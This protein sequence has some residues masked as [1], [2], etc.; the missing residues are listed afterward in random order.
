MK[1]LTK[2]FLSEADREKILKAVEKAEA[3]TSGEIVPMVV[4]CSYHYPLANVIGAITIAFPLSILL[5]QIVGELFWIGSKNMWLFIG[6]LT[7]TFTVFLAIVKRVPW[8]KRIFISKKEMEEEVREAALTGFF[9]EEL[10][11]TRDETGVLIFISI[12]EHKV[13]VLADK[14]INAKVPEGHW[15]GIVSHIVDG[16]KNRRQGAAICEAVTKA[17]ELLKANFPIK[18]DDTD[19]LK[20][21]IVQD[22]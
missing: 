12:F 14:G 16:I 20:N 1:D 3:Q 21:L 19:E 6:I 4:S 9:K 18:P 13:W 2:K 7:V 17:G 22:D 15:E 8:L 10:Y 5:T 11:R